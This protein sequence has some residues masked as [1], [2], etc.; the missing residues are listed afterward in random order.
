M[1]PKARFAL[2]AALAA[3]AALAFAAEGGHRRSPYVGAMAVDAQTG[4][5]LFS[6]R[7][8]AAAYPASVTKLMTLLLVMEDVRA[9]KYSYDTQV[10]ATQEAYM[11]EPSWVGLKAGERMSVKDLCYALMV[12]SANDAAI[13]LGVNSSGSLQA[14]VDR[15]NARAAELGM[16][17]TAYY[18]PNGLPP[19]PKK[20]YPW[21][22][23]NVSTA[24][25]QATLAVAI[26]KMPEAL[27]FTS[28]KTCD[29]VKTKGGYRVFVT[30]R[31]SETPRTTVLANGEK[32]V[33][34]MRNHNNVMRTD[35]LKIVNADGKEAVDGLKTGYIDAGGSSV[36]LTGRRG[37]RRAVV[38]VLGSSSS[39][40]RDANAR[41]LMEDAL[42]AL[43]W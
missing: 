5:V 40:E 26:L 37:A 38:V 36:V 31:G 34:S 10:A 15:M 27:E 33:K 19:N 13:V 32:I 39:K 7:A 20:K 6:D 41:R 28:V 17:G 12:E 14:F 43:D 35:K 21:K 3:S 30:R 29:L 8:D 22:R 11:S 18:N 4:K 25:D 23:F 1:R 2:A 9:G 24:A 16:A 42:D